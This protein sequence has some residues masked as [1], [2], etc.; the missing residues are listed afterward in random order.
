MKGFKLGVAIIIA[1]MFSGTLSSAQDTDDFD[2][3]FESSQDVVVEDSPSLVQDEK[4]S[5]LDF[6]SLLFP[7]NFTGIWIRKLAS[8]IIT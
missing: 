1:A 5:P 4:K 2:S 8:G 7:L 6:T 3:M